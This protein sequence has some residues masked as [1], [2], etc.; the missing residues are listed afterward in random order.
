MVTKKDHISAIPGA[1]PAGV[2]GPWLSSGRF[3]ALPCGRP[4]Y[5][6]LL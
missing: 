6:L 4:V 3:K 2:T 1:S 5:Y